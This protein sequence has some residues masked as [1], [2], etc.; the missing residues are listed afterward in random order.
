MLTDQLEVRNGLGFLIGDKFW[1]SVELSWAD[2]DL[3]GKP[4]PG[5]YL[6]LGLRNDISVKSR[7]SKFTHFNVLIFLSSFNHHVIT[8]EDCFGFFRWMFDV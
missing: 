8:S 5:L 2:R 7:L 6:E 1:S 4:V 3:L